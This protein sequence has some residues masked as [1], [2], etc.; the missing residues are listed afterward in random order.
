MMSAKGGEVDASSGLDCLDRERRGQMAL[1][2]AGRT[3]EMHYLGAVDEGELGECEDTLPVERGLKGE[4]EAGERL[5][6][7]GR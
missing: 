4:V 3:E 5:D 2:G 6:G 1:A 7:G